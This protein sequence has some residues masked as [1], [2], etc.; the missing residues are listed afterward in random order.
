MSDYISLAQGC[1]QS[2]LIEWNA[3]QMHFLR[4]S[5]ANEGFALTDI[6]VQDQLCHTPDNKLYYCS[7][8]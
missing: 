7:I 5:Q 4:D 8:R 1:Y 6:F 3:M 2:T